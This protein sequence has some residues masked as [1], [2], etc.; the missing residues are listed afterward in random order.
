MGVSRSSRLALHLGAI[1]AVVGLSKAHAVANH[2]VWSGSS[3]FAWSI[4]YVGLLALTAYGF[5]LPEQP[6]TRRGAWAAAAASTVA[7]A[8][9]ISIAQLFAGD[10]LL[11]RFVVFGSAVVLVPWYAL[12]AAIARDGRTRAGERDRVVVVATPDEVATL[13][14]ELDRAPE[15]PALVL[16]LLAP[17][18][19]ISTSLP[20]ASAARAGAR[21]PAT[22]VVLSRRAQT[23]DDVVL[24]ASI[25]HE[26]G[27]RIRTLSLFYEQWLGKLP[28]GELERVSL[29]FDIGE[30]HGTRYARVKRM[31]DI[32]LGLGGLVVLALVTPVVIVGDLIANRGPLFYRQP[33]TGRANTRF[34]ILKFRTMRECTP[35]DA[36]D[37]TTEHDTR[38]TSF[39]GF[40]RRTH[41]DELPQVINILRGDLSVVGRVRAA[42]PRRRAHRQDPVLPPAPPRAARPHRLGA[43]EVPVRGDR[44]RD[45]RETP[46]RILLSPT[47]ELGS[48]RTNHR[49]HPP[50]RDGT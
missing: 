48:R 13:E 35:D 45:A 8:V 10:A 42:A 40:L 41:L 17:E 18:D 24:Q 11:P 30:L 22:V 31:L 16:G 29:L 6:R 25:L 14:A 36:T 50:Q 12:C 9:A 4:A 20:A 27:I 32:V 39:G 47:P 15:R 26:E 43:G 33:R 46:V 49:S 28:I 7:A 1:A 21:H 38:I 3:R 37:W 2:Y 44:S 23:D 5:G 34:D 19:A